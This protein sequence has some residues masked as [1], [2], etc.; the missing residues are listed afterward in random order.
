MTINHRVTHRR[1]TVR[2]CPAGGD[3]LVEEMNPVSECKWTL[4]NIRKPCSE[5][6][7]F[8]FPPR[9]QAQLLFLPCEW[10]EGC[11]QTL[12]HFPAGARS[13]HKSVNV[14]YA[15]VFVA[16]KGRLSIKLWCGVHHWTCCT[17]QVL[18]QRC[19]QWHRGR[20]VC[21]RH[22][23]AAFTVTE[24]LEGEQPAYSLKLQTGCGRSSVP[25]WNSGWCF[26]V[27]LSSSWPPEALRDVSSIIKKKKKLQMKV[28][29]RRVA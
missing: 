20:K 7:R 6:I 24:T 27:N 26:R 3:L 17:L 22:R 13:L 25:P 11:R 1:D 16:H 23:T 2:H 14:G 29:I 28:E 12:S 19:F 4:R 9:L 15:K 21:I 18:F 8:D 10:E 5:G